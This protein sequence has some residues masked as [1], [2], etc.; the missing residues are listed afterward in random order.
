[1]L[2][3]EEDYVVIDKPGGVP[4]V[5]TV[6][7]LYENCLHMTG[8]AIEAR[9]P[10]RVTHRLDQP[11]SG[12]LVLAKT[13]AFC[14][15]FN[16]LLSERGERED[17]RVTKVYRVLTERAVPRGV[18][19]ESGGALT[20]YAE[21]GV[22][23]KGRPTRT[24]VHDRADGPGGNGKRVVCKLRVLRCDGVAGTGMYESEVVLLTGRTHQIRAQFAHI[25]CPVAGDPIYNGGSGEA[26]EEEVR[27]APERIGLR[28]ARVTVRDDSGAGFFPQ[29]EGVVFEVK[30]CDW[31]WWGE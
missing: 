27:V 20:H 8:R 2:R 14:S 22:R 25:G 5:P 19:S 10:L 12:V 1:M 23:S 21:I 6:D 28:A 11:T 4:T 17:P 31:G 13:K 9:G 7:N 26:E 29:S 18:L 24:V 3:E 16:Q 30:S 15:H